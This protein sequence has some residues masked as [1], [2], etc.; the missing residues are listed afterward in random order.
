MKICDPACGVGKFL[1]EA[2]LPHLKDY[3]TV[4]NGN[5]SEKITLHGFDKG[6]DKEEQRTII[7]AKANM[8]IYF[9]DLIKEHSEITT[10]F[11]KLFNETFELKTNS[12][13]GTLRDPIE[14]EYDLILTNPPYV[15]SG[16]SNLKDE[17]KKDAELEKYYKVNALGVEGLFM[18]WIIKALKPG[19]K[20]FIVIPDGIPVSYTHLTLPTT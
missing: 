3:Y 11:A 8:L 19:G 4:S 15:T 2:V 7:L 17:I 9:S 6:F 13:L 12:I 5:L 20:A 16:S 18:E 14:N 10:Q 1:L